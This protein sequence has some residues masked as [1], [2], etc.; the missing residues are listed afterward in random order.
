VGSAKIW[1]VIS[2]FLFGFVFFR[3]N[4]IW[5][6]SVRHSAGASLSYQLFNREGRI[7]RAN[8]FQWYFGWKKS[9]EIS[10]MLTKSSS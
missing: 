5:N 4:H 2:N 9:E 3:K 1:L 7:V 8:A 6:A 10:E